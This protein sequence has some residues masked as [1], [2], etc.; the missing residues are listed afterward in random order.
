M[1][2][3]VLDHPNFDDYDLTS[4]RGMIYGASPI[5]EAQMAELNLL[6]RPTPNA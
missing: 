4:L 2:R 5:A 1:L 3:A 6:L